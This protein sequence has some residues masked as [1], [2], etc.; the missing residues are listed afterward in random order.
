MITNLL[1]AALAAGCAMLWLRLSKANEANVALQTELVKLRLRL[2]NA[3][4]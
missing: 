2:R 1:M 4:A 3:R